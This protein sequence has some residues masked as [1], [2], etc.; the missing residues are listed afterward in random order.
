[1][2][3]Y[4]DQDAKTPAPPGGHEGPPLGGPGFPGGKGR[5]IGLVLGAVVVVSLVAVAL[6]AGGGHQRPTAA[7]VV[8]TSK[9][10]SATQTTAAHAVRTTTA[11]AT[12]TAVPSSVTPTA[13]PISPP[14]AAPPTVAPSVTAG[15]AVPWSPASSNTLVGDNGNPKD[16]PAAQPQP[17]S[18]AGAHSDNMIKAIVTLVT[19]QDWVY[20]HPNPALVEAYE[21]PGGSAYQQEVQFVE[22]LAQKGWHATGVPSIVDWVAV[23]ESPKQATVAG[24]KVN[25]PATVT[26]VFDRKAA[27]LYDGSGSIV[28]REVALGRVAYSMTLGKDAAG[29]WRIVTSTQLHPTGG[30]G[31]LT[32]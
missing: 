19:Y 31:S 16:W 26:I 23:T 1:M 21:A 27:D 30:L 28:A 10:R 12:S 13:S 25:M 6:A 29:Q 3:Q 8:R 15:T 5:I 4:R 20:A 2:V 18:L 22:H 17:P 24:H 32:R 7:P 11:P 9:P 14:I